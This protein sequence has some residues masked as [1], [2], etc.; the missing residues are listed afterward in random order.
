MDKCEV[1]ALEAESQSD[2]FSLPWNLADRGRN[3]AIQWKI[4]GIRKGK[5]WGNCERE[6][7]A[8]TASGAKKLCTTHP[9]FPAQ[10][11]NKQVTRVPQYHT[12][13]G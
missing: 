8:H 6:K 9:E 11:P 4:S 10:Y 3:N 1:L 13:Y 12:N 2:R 5:R 7:L